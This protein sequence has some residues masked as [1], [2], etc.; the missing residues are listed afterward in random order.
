MAW[1]RERTGSSPG[2]AGIWGRDCSAFAAMFSP[3]VWG[4]RDGAGQW[5]KGWLSPR[6]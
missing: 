3:G 5:I 1:S 2:W 4:A 6:P